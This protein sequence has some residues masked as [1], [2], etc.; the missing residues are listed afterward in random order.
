[1]SEQSAERA[2]R[3]WHTD[4]P[5]RLVGRGHPIGD[6]LEAYDWEVVERAPRCL[7]VRM[8]LPD[9]VKNP[10]GELFGGFT[11]TYVDFLGLHVFHTAR[12]PDE[13]HRWLSTANLH[14]EYFAPIV[15][16]TFDAVGE[17]IHRRG[18]SAYVQIRFLTA[19]SACAAI[20]HATFIQHRD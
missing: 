8:H 13:P 4:D 17:V 11:P 3:A 18:R 7:R 5:N 9:R 12:D 19:E 10:R 20:A 15:G 1:M 2:L 14:V 6:F 16:P